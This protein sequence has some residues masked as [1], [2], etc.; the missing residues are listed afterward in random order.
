MKVALNF[1]ERVH[2]QLILT[3][4]VGNYILLKEC[5]ELKEAI[6]F[7][8]KETKDCGI[9][10]TEGG[11]IAWNNNAKD[12]TFEISEAIGK[13]IFKPELEKLN[14]K[15]VLPDSHFKLYEIFVVAFENDKKKK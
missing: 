14:D 3:T 13:N 7:T 5:R 15:N 2:L 10:A 11:G 9:K 1:T 4:A 8:E 12:E 6:S